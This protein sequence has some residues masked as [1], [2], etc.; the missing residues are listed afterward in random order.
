M[1]LNMS[2][3]DR[4]LRA[5]AALVIA[6]LYTTGVITGAWGIA[7]LV[8]ACIFMLTSLAGICPLYSILGFS[9]RKHQKHIH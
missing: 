5:L 2:A 3:A 7:L 6:F 8:I 1:K 4:V 9:T